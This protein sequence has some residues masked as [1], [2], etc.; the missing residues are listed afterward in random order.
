MP[1]QE[2]LFVFNW[3]QIHNQSLALTVYRGPS[4]TLSI[5]E[6]LQTELLAS[7]MVF[8]T[9][10]VDSLKRIKIWPMGWRPVPFNQNC[11]TIS[12][13]ASL[14]AHRSGSILYQPIRSFMHQSTQVG[15]ESSFASE[16]MNQVPGV[17]LLPIRVC[18]SSAWWSALSVSVMCY[19]YLVKTPHVRPASVTLGLGLWHRSHNTWASLPKPPPLT[20]KLYVL[21]ISQL[22]WFTI[23]LFSLNKVSP[24]LPHPK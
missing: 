5:R 21:D 9:L 22:T 2:V 23:E 17:E 3:A 16:W 10:W 14:S 24:P 1:A 20:E 18:S 15:L 19:V 13:F 12:S 11:A 7:G 6:K 4:G 8:L